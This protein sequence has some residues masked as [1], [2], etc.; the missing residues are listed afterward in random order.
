MDFGFSSEESM[1]QKA[2]R[3]W[4]NKECSREIVRE[5]DE[6]SQ[7]P[8]GL[9]PQLIELGFYG[10]TIEEKYG[11]EGKNVMAAC[12]VIMEI[13]ARYPALARCYATNA[14]LGGMLLSTL[15]TESQKKKYLPALANGKI[16]IAV[17]V[18]SLEN[19][20][21]KA[22]I[23][24]RW[25]PEGKGYLLEGT[26]NDV[27][28][29]DRSDVYLLPVRMIDTETP[30]IIYMLVES[31]ASGVECRPGCERMGHKGI[32]TCTV[33]CKNVFVPEKDI[34]SYTGDSKTVKGKPGVWDLYLLA[35]AFEAVGIAKG[36]C[37]ST[38]DY[39]KQRVQF[40]Q[41]I[42]KFPAVRRMVSE[43]LKDIEA[44]ELISLKAAWKAHSGKFL[45]QESAFAAWS[46]I[47]AARKAAEDGLQLYGGYGYTPEYDIQLYFRDITVLMSSATAYERLSQRIGMAAGLSA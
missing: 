28:N 12:L 13:A 3:D 30:E 31:N 43:V 10:L 8:G 24:G 23:H 47:A 39:V 19:I 26:L 1:I 46:S 15:E 5:M 14:F 25:D 38:L 41:A 22:S 34:L 18:S 4:V 44:S 7:Y 32:Q 16:C 29:A 33:H 37:A 27:E 2:I 6:N 40:S 42:G 36:A 11:G 45:G 9:L 17:K 20:N 21:S 35:T